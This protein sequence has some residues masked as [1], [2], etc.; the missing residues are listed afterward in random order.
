[1]P[2]EIAALALFLV[3][4]LPVLDVSLSARGGP[5]TPPPGSRC[6]LGPRLGW[7]VL[8]LMLGPIG[9]LL[10]RHGRGRGHRTS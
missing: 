5:W 1:M 6:P 3:Y 8:V 10:Y 2:V 9:W 7:L 4:V